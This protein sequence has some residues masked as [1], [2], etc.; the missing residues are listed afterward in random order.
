MTT[1]PTQEAHSTTA[2]QTYSETAFPDT[3]GSDHYEWP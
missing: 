2:Q 3:I 1:S